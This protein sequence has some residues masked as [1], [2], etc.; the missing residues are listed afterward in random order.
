MECM[1]K[2]FLLTAF[3]AAP[4]FADCPVAPDIAA[5]IDGLIVAVQDAPN[6]GAA[7]VLSNEM[8]TFWA[9]AP[10]DRAQRL[11]DEGM[12]RRGVSDLDGATASFDALVEYCPD[13]AEGYNQR[14]FASFLREDYAAALPDLDRAIA[15]QPRHIPAMAG[16]G[17]TLI[18]LGR[19]REGQ[20]EIRRAVA[21]NPW[22]SERVY[23]RL[24]PENTDL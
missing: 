10:D 20:V 17:L 2:S 7:R 12:S 24:E 22:L 4:A 15:L 6:E 9:K 23:L 13:F 14:A 19:I 3:F 1:L 21:L 11:L 18:R 16:K 8:W 5:D